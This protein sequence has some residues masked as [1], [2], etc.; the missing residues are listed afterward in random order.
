MISELFSLLAQGKPAPSTLHDMV[1]VM[2]LCDAY[3]NDMNRR[4]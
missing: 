2:K 4:I 1:A 3:R